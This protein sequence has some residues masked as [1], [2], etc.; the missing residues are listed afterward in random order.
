MNLSDPLSPNTLQKTVKT[1]SHEVTKIGSL[2]LPPLVNMV[3]D[4][5]MGKLWSR[6]LMCPRTAPTHLW[7]VLCHHAKKLGNP[8]STQSSIDMMIKK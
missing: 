4:G 7:T 1:P 6:Y 8:V 5:G 2:L 3:S